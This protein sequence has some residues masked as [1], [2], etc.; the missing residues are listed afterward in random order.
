MHIL[1]ANDGSQSALG[2]LAYALRSHPDASVT[3][4]HVVDTGR[5]WLDGPWTEG[6][7]QERAEDIAMECHEVASEL[8]ERHDTQLETE[9]TTGI[10][11]KE[12]IQFADDGNVDLI[13]IG[14]HAE[15]SNGDSPHIGGTAESVV[16]RAL[17]SVSVV[18]EDPEQLNHRDLPGDILVPID[19]SKQ[20]ISAL[21]YAREHFPDG[22][23]TALH[24]VETVG[25]F[26]SVDPKGT[27]VNEEIS[28]LRQEAEELLLDVQEQVNV[29]VQTAVRF[30]NPG[31]EIVEYASEARCDQIVLGTLGRSGIARILLGSVAESVV[32]RSRIPTTLVR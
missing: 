31:R 17:Q 28:V 10:P 3:N 13:V 1:V 8:A 30:G 22:S 27:Y 24:V 19:G 5:E 12:I 4:L 25:G 11:H 32:R 2:A 6:S 15:L 7:W 14:R 26:P 9:T 29:D 18:P 20:S 16:R 21:Q 23:I